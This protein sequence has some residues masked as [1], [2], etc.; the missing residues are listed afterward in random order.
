M[1]LNDLLKYNYTQK[2]MIYETELLIQNIL[3]YIEAKLF[4]VSGC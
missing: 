4:T 1:L 2:I 3:Q